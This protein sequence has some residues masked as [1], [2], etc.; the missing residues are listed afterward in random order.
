MLS[1]LAAI[2]V[3]IALCAVLVHAVGFVGIGI[4]STAAVAAAAVLNFALLSRDGALLTGRDFADLLK[5]LICTAVMGAA[6]YAFDGFAALQNDLIRV[7]CC[8]AVGIAVYG[9]A[10]LL[11]PTAE[12]RTLQERILKRSPHD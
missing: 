11:L 3:N 8:G 4:A 9:A 10:C 12:V 6:V 7:L 1:S 5:M 2:V